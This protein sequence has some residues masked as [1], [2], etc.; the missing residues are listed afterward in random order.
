M[1]RGRAARAR[2]NMRENGAGSRPGGLFA[3][4]GMYG[5]IETPA[6]GGSLG[7]KYGAE[8]ANSQIGEAS[9]HEKMMKQARSREGDEFSSEGRLTTNGKKA[10]KVQGNLAAA[11]RIFSTSFLHGAYLCTLMVELRNLTWPSWKLT[12]EEETMSLIIHNPTTQ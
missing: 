5:G 10:R 8:I 7:E 1:L 2:A 12:E 11:T 6:A 3:S 9:E 4:G